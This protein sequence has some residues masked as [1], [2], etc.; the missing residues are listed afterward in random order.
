MLQLY[1]GTNNMRGKIILLAK[2]ALTF[3][4]KLNNKHLF[5]EQ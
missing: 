4:E 3:L 5:N 1:Y 2:I